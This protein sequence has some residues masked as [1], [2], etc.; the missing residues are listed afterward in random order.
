MKLPTEAG[1]LGLPWWGIAASC[2][3][4]ATAAVVIWQTWGIPFYRPQPETLGGMIRDGKPIAQLIKEGVMSPRRKLIEG[5]PEEALRPTGKGPD[6]N[7]TRVER[8]PVPP[9][10]EFTPRMRMTREKAKVDK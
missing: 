1:R 7:M 6:L 4:G 10:M 2:V 9:G 3:A 5:I 8:M